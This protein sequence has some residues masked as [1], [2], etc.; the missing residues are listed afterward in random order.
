MLWCLAS[1]WIGTACDTH[2]E[3][4]PVQNETIPAQIDTVEWNPTSFCQLSY[5]SLTRKDYRMHKHILAKFDH[6][7]KR[8]YYFSSE[9]DTLNFFVY[10]QDIAAFLGGLNP[11]ETGV[12]K[13]LTNK[14][15]YRLL[16]YD[17]AMLNFGLGI[18]RSKE[19]KWSYFWDQVAHP[20]CYSQALD[21]TIRG[22]ELNYISRNAS[23]D[24]IKEK[25]IRHL[26]QALTVSPEQLKDFYQ[27]E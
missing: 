16:E 20:L 18:R 23:Q 11:K 26:N 10:H 6:P 24:T 17:P 5:D 12:D 25:L 8:G 13:R 22:I 2:T 14:V 9:G 19:E 15:I 27:I 21:S 3:S 4:L 7:E 1:L